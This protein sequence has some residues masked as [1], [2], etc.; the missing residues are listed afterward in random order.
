VVL[1]LL[2]YRA[3]TQPVGTLDTS[4]DVN[5]EFEARAAAIKAS[6]EIETARF[7]LATR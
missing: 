4:V 1:R 3:K 2:Q 5:T 7:V 6:K